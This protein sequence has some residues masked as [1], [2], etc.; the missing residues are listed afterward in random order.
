MDKDLTE[1]ENEI[2][3]LLDEKLMQGAL[4]SED[5]LH[6]LLE[7]A[8]AEDEEALRE[9]VKGIAGKF[10]IFEEVILFE[11]RKK[12]ESLHDI[13]HEF[14]EQL[15]KEDPAKA[16]EISKLALNKETK[17]EQLFEAS[18]EFKEFYENKNK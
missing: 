5:C 6:I 7:L 14:V 17:L 12:Q 3:K 16:A 2:R 18:P 9:T 13:V 15:I 11:A 10:P 1:L 4:S 8:K